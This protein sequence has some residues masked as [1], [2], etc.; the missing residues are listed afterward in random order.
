MSIYKPGRLNFCVL[1]LLFG[2][3]S[4]GFA[5]QT[6]GVY[7]NED[8]TLCSLAGKSDLIFNGKV[9]R[10]QLLVDQAA[11]DKEYERWNDFVAKSIEAGENVDLVNAPKMERFVTGTVYALEIKEIIS[12]KK[13]M[14][15]NGSISVLVKGYPF[16]IHSGIPHFSIES[17]YL[18]HL[19][20]AG[21]NEF[22]PNSMIWDTATNEAAKPAFEKGRLFVI[23]P[24][25]INFPP[26]SEDNSDLVEKAK[27][28]SKQKK[29]CRLK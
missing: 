15:A 12:A 24:G 8:S 10:S 16:R 28:F 7:Y 6:P 4:T 20:S 21:R 25:A 14:P 13:K 3:V 27:R 9:S 26:L 18:F 17:N 11:K 22:S 2:L 1:L 5:F 19:S 29:S 23:T